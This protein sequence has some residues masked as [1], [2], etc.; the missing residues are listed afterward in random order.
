MLQIRFPRLAALI[1]LIV[2]VFLLL[3]E[4]AEAQIGR[5]QMLRTRT[6]IVRRAITKNLQGA[7]K[8]KLA[9]VRGATGPVTQLSLSSDQRY[10][11]TVL[12]NDTAR[13]WDLGQ[14]MEL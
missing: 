1:S 2:T 10:L 12:G 7:V 11:A 5:T 8:P 14:G 3:P 4:P 9:I 6:N 13:L